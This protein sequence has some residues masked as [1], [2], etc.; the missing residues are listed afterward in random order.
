MRPDIVL[1]APGASADQ[2]TTDV[3][4]LTGPQHPLV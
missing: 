2:N 3:E 4:V 1:F